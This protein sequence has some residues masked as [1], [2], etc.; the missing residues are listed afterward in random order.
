MDRRSGGQPRKVRSLDLLAEALQDAQRPLVSRE[1]Q[2]VLE[3]EVFGG[4]PCIVQ[5][6]GV[7]VNGGVEVRLFNGDQSVGPGSASKGCSS[8]VCSQLRSTTAPGSG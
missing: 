2:E 3:E 4:G 5:A 7:G 1:T 6:L 8:L